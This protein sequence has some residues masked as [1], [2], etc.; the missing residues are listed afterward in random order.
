[1]TV[2]ARFPMEARGAG[3]AVTVCVG[4]GFSLL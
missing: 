3:G 4:L 2:K 1:M